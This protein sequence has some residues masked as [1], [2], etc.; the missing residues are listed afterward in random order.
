LLQAKVK[1]IFTQLYPLA[2]HHSQGPPK[3]SFKYCIYQGCSSTVQL[4]NYSLTLFLPHCIHQGYSRTI[5]LSITAILHCSYC[6]ATRNGGRK[7]QYS[8]EF[9]IHVILRNDQ[10]P[11]RAVDKVFQVII[12]QFPFF[13]FYNQFLIART[14]EYSH[15]YY[16]LYFILYKCFIHIL[17]KTLES[18]QLVCF[19]QSF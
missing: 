7:F 10:T 16:F 9:H 3:C 11:T 19:L 17:K 2:E 1:I 14:V 8:A 15:N 12:P 4:Y 5:Q 13:A 6:S 18:T